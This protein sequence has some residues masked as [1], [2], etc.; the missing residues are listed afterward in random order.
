M[1]FWGKL[2]KENNF[3]LILPFH[4]N[5]KKPFKHRKVTFK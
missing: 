5:Q 4:E 2:C 3:Y 1:A